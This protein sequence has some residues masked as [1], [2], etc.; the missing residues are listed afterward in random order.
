MIGYFK[1]WYFHIGLDAVLYF[2]PIFSNEH[3]FIILSSHGIQTLNYYQFCVKYIHWQSNSFLIIFF[4]HNFIFICSTAT[5][6]G[7]ICTSC[8]IL[9]KDFFLNKN[10]SLSSQNLSQRLILFIYINLVN[11]YKN[12]QIS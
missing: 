9:L 6:T 12:D 1:T 3:L 11:P 8:T 2:E 7:Y 10:S 4:E 5:E